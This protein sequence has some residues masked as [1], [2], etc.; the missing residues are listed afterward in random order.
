MFFLFV[1][2][3]RRVTQNRKQINRLRHFGCCLL[4]QLVKLT[5]FVEFVRLVGW[6]TVIQYTYNL[7]EKNVGGRALPFK[8]SDSFLKKRFGAFDL[9]YIFLRVNEKTK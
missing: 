4:T 2:S 3:I 5:N 9:T 7:K 1:L 8:N 6:L